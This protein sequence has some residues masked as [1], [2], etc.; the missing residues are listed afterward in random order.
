MITRNTPRTAGRAMLNRAAFRAAV[1]SL[2]CRR[3]MSVAPEAGGLD[4][5]S[6]AEV[7]FL[8]QVTFPTATD[9]QGTRV[10]GLSGITYDAKAGRYYAI[11]DDRSEFNA[12]RFYTL[13]VD[14]DDGAL[15]AGDVDLEQV[16]TLRDPAGNAFAAKGVDPEGI[17]V[18]GKGTVLV[19]SEGDATAGIAPFVNAFSIATGRQT[20]ALPVDDKFLPTPEAGVRNNLAFESLTITPERRFAFTATENA[21]LQDG[22]PAGL[23][24]ETVSRIVKYDLV[25]GRSVGEFAYVADAVAAPPVPAGAFATNGLVDLLAIDNADTLLA[26]ERSF[27]VGVGNSIKLYEATVQ[28]AVKVD[29]LDALDGLEPDPAADKRLVLDLAD[30]GIALDNVE[31]ITFGPKLADG[32]QSMILVSDDNFSATQVTQVLAFAVE[33]HATPAVGPAYETPSVVDNE[34][35]P[36]GVTQGDADDPAVYVNPDNA[37][38]SFVI[39]TLKEGGLQ[40]YNLKGE[41]LQTIAPEGVRYNNV[42][43]VYGFKI[44]GKATDLAVVS[45]RFADSIAVYKIDRAA[46]KLS[47]LD[48]TGLD[49][50]L[51][52]GNEEATA[53]G[54]TAYQAPGGKTYAFV[55]QADGDLIRQLELKDNGDGGVK[56]TVVRTLQVPIP[57]DGELADAQSEAMVVDRQA[58]HLYVAEENLG[59]LKFDAAPDGGTDYDLIHS[60]EADYLRADVEGLALYYGPNGTGH[61]IA[62]SQGDNSYAV[63]D[64]KGDNA[65]VGSFYVGYSSGLKGRGIDSAEETDG[66]EVVNVNLGGPFAKG[67]LVVQDGNDRPQATL[68]DDGEIENAAANFKLVAWDKVAAAFKRTFGKSLIVD[69]GGYDPRAGRAFIAPRSVPSSTAPLEVGT[70]IAEAILG[71]S[72]DPLD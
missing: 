57:E 17:A 45:D 40:T 29:G 12:A 67:L 46:R 51:F 65:Y 15:D 52:A 55:T 59:I 34:D 72:Q 26:V 33:L 11:S 53:Y 49:G 6:V 38:K 22:P 35:A 68:N 54:L 14:L 47:E 48:V 32:R 61:L 13:D 64:R 28:G 66:L 8:G 69:T 5:A 60:T 56:A 23:D 62:S 30:L 1:E 20:R 27:S 41:L 58:G 37:R 2:E 16:T 21:L 25:T 42:D 71:E 19:S 18:T 70:G 9:F 4:R 24:Q 63:F 10:G 36:K 43:V 44:G 31:G 39:T 3:L 7:E 50:P